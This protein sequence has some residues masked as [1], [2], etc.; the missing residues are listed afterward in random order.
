QLARTLRELGWSETSV[1]SESPQ[2][3]RAIHR[4]LTAGLLG[5]LGVRDEP[6][7]SYTG[8]RGIKFWIH[9]GSAVS[10]PG[11][12]I[13]AAELVETTRL[14]ART[15]AAIE[16]R[17]LEDIGGHLMRREHY[18]PQWDAR[19]GEVIALERGSLYGLP[20]Y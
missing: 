12:W 6:E 9:P 20:V 18:E 8:A 11:R 13:A 7:A 10:K 14:F 1:D 17:W 15:I 2:G 4:A 16:P 3:Y 5:N 19:R